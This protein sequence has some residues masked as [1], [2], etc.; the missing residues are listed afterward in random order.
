M[1]GAAVVGAAVAGAGVSAVEQDQADQQRERQRE[2]WTKLSLR[3]RAGS[4][5]LALQAW[6][7]AV[8]V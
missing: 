2:D 7:D 8:R 6:H 5:G 1:V 4:R 3:R